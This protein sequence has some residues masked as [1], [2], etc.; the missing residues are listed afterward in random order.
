MLHVDVAEYVAR[1]R[2]LANRAADNRADVRDGD[3]GNVLDHFEPPT[4]DEDVLRHDETMP[5]D[6]WIA[7]YFDV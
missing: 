3:F 7:R 4:P 2:W 5:C 1:K 6:A